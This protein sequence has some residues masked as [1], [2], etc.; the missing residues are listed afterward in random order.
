MMV[1]NKTAERLRDLDF[2][3]TLVKTSKGWK[4]ILVQ[5]L[6]YKE[7]GKHV[8]TRRSIATLN[9]NLRYKNI[10][11]CGCAKC[12]GVDINYAACA[13]EKPLSEAYI[14]GH[15]TFVR[16]TRWLDICDELCLDT[17]PFESDRPARV[18]I[19]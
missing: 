10:I 4:A 11:D 9:E 19:K 18:V 8:I 2:V 7:D 5:G 1:K 15:S 6:A 17:S 14:D 16:R 3:E 13:K 12:D